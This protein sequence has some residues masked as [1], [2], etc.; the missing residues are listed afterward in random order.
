MLPESKGILPHSRVVGRRGKGPRLGRG[1]FTSTWREREAAA[2]AAAYL[3]PP[4]DKL[5]P[6]AKAATTFPRRLFL[7]ML[8]GNS[9]PGGAEVQ[10]RI[11]PV[12]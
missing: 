4:R 12:T 3:R 11:L 7:Q 5:L 6:P 2:L 8:V 9:Q 10:P 1:L